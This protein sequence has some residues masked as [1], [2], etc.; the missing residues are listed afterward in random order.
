MQS[1]LYSVQCSFKNGKLH[2]NQEG[3]IIK[4]VKK[5]QQISYNG[6]HARQK[7]QKMHYVTERAVFELRSEG[8]TLTE[9]APGIDLKTQVLDLMEFIPLIAPDLKTM[10]PKLFQ[11]HTPFGLKEIICTKH[12]S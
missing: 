5:V 10:N 1:T 4:L 12:I 8:L 9:I 2:I 11:E 6:K 7:S 3:N